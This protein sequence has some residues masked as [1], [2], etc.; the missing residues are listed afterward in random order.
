MKNLVL[1]FVLFLFVVIGPVRSQE[2][3]YFHYTPINGLPTSDIYDLAQDS[4]SR[5]WLATGNGVIVYDGYSFQNLATPRGIPDNS[6]IKMFTGKK[7]KYWFLSFAG[8]LVYTDHGKLQSYPLNDTIHKLG[9]TY[10]LTSLFIDSTDQIFFTSRE[11]GKII[12]IDATQTIRKFDSTGYPNRVLTPFFI[13]SHEDLHMRTV[14][15]ELYNTYQEA[16]GPKWYRYKNGGVEISKPNQKPRIYFQDSRITRA[17]KDREYHYWISTEGNGLFYLP[18]IRMNIFYAPKPSKNTNIITFCLAESSC[19]F[20][21]ADGRL[22]KADIENGQLINPIEILKEETGK[23]IRSILYAAD[24]SLWLTQSKYLR[25]TANGAKASPQHIILMKYYDINQAPDQDIYIASR[26]GFIEY[27]G[28]RLIYDSRK[29]LFYQHTK[30]VL[31]TKE[32]K[33]YLGTMKGLF[34]YENGKYFDLQE[35]H[36]IFTKPIEILREWNKRVVI[37]TATSGVAIINPDQTINLLNKENGLQSLL[38]EDIYCD[39][40]SVLWIGTNQGLTE[41]IFTSSATWKIQN[42]TIWDGLP[43]PEVHKIERQGDFLWL[44][45]SN[46]MAS[47]MPENVNQRIICPTIYIEQLVIND[48]DTLIPEN[49]I[50]TF[51]ENKRT[52]SIYFKGVH[53]TGHERLTYEYR[54]L[55]YDST[56]ISTRN[57]SARFQDLSPGNYMFEVRAK[58]GESNRS[59]NISR[60]HFSIAPYFYETWFFYLLIALISLILFTGLT[61][62]IIKQIERRTRFKTSFLWMQQKALRLQMNPHFIFNSL[63]SVQHFILNKEEEAAGLYLSSFAKLMRKVLENSMHNLIP[64]DEELETITLYLDLEKVRFE[65]KFDYQ[66]RIEKDLS[67][68]EVKIP[69]MLIQPFLENA[70]RHGLANKPEKGLLRVHISR[71]DPLLKVEIEDNG[72]GLKAAAEINARRQGHR[73]SGMKNIEERIRMLNRLLDHSIR[74]DVKDLSEVSPELSGTRIELFIPLFSSEST[75]AFPKT[76]FKWIK[77]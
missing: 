72:I 47:F 76:F 32:G 25:Y 42:F 73:S 11:P 65:D 74:L 24:G 7:E 16:N 38:I 19:Y 15:E 46:G 2:P 33:I 36:P 77:K 40:D 3:F 22:F 12:T 27:R 39:N 75:N 52:L 55:N 70:I 10:F 28:Q 57:M 58:E 5:I 59:K 21:T 64:L 18:S 68:T 6:F 29:D 49:T 56:W 34:V 20:S 66:I 4:L 23:Y 41:A 71:K 44:A 45:T 9:S 51:E 53:F 63:N 69:P 14:P 8:Y 35:V 31:K 26:E 60:V 37:G 54:L 48:K 67:V 43:S 30:T 50:M 13:N 61:F 62:L 17:L 1:F